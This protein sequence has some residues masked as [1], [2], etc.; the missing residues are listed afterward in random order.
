[1]IYSLR[2]SSQTS[3]NRIITCSSKNDSD[4]LNEF[5]VL[6]SKCHEI[7]LETAPQFSPN[8][9]ICNQDIHMY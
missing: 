7:C 1:M 8:D 4:Y 2:I 6:F 5:T 3:M 9:A